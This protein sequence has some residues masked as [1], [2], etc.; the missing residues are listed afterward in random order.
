[1][2]PE[3]NFIVYYFII[4]TPFLLFLLKLLFTNFMVPYHK[5]RA[6]YQKMKQDLDWPHIETQYRFLTHLF[7]GTAGKLTSKIYRCAHLMQNKEFVYGEIDFLSFYCILK[8]ATPKEGDIFYDLGSGTGKAV[9]CA[10]YF[11]HFSKSKGIELLLPL[12]NKANFLLKQVDSR[13]HE[14]IEFLHA[15]FLNHDFSDADIVYIAA[16]CLKPATWETLIIKLAQLKPGSRVIV[17]TQSIHHPKFQ[18]IYQANEVMSWGLCP[19]KIYQ[20]TDDVQ[21]SIEPLCP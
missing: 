21:L 3:A 15:D 8:R 14:H 11:F 4:C 19:V 13:Y 20:L 5:K 2:N 9:F 10:A 16:T 7:Q 18:L 6:L 12:Y 17:A 1:M